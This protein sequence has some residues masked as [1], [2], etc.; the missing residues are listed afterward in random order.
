MANA[1]AYSVVRLRRALGAQDDD[2]IDR[3]V[4]FD[5]LAG[6]LE[7]T[8]EDIDEIRHAFQH[9][10][11]QS[12]ERLYPLVRIA[13]G[14]ETAAPFDPD[15]TEIRDENAL[16]DAIDVIPDRKQTWNMQPSEVAAAV[17]AARPWHQLADMFHIEL[18][19]LNALLVELGPPNRPDYNPEGQQEAFEDYLENRRDAIS[20]RLREAHLE[21]FRGRGDLSGYVAARPVPLD[22][23]PEW[24]TACWSPTDLMM[25]ER[26][27]SWLADVGAS[28]DL[29]RHSTLAPLGDVRGGNTDRVWDLAGRSAVVRAWCAEH[30]TEVPAVWATDQPGG[31]LVALATDNG[32]LDFEVLDVHQLIG[33]FDHLGSWPVDMPHSTDQGTLGLSDE[34]LERAAKGR[35]R[36]ASSTKVTIGDR[37]LVAGPQ[38]YAD[39]YEHLTRTLDPGFLAT[40]RRST[41]LR[42]VQ[43]GER[44]P[45]R[46]R[47]D[48]PPPKSPPRDSD[49]VRAFVGL[50]GEVCALHWLQRQYRLD[51]DACWVSTYRGVVRDD[52]SGNDAL[53]Y[54]FCV[55]K[56]R[57]VRYFEVKASRGDTNEFELTHNEAE[58]AR[59]HTAR[60][61]YTILLI[62]N[63]LNEERA[64][65][66]LPNPFS[67]EGRARYR[68]TN[69]GIRYRFW[70]TP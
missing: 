64:L 11:V 12:L 61:A 54:D 29:D 7:L 60:G 70:P 52:G 32:F 31:A 39:L 48:A 57:S 55:T 44:A 21:T 3:D 68:P 30:D 9:A 35:S 18:A 43:P 2:V 20:S 49:S 62:T 63:V 1:L 22:A 41:E 65:T 38:S 66:V 59:S 26:L 16:L 13:F 69:A 53:G 40:P 56:G 6:A 46:H 19:E 51:D 25:A 27:A 17:A 67:A 36:T 15:T 10:I 33:W 34:A 58:F 14:S 42:E 4:G 47:G 23:D 37:E 24:V 5:V 8:L 50:A 45:Q 28:P